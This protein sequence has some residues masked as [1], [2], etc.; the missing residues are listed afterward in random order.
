MKPRTVVLALFLTLSFAPS[1]LAQNAA[2]EAA[3]QQAKEENKGVALYFHSDEFDSPQSLEAILPDDWSVKTYLERKYVT[4]S[5]DADTEEGEI[6]ARRYAQLGV[7]PVLSLID[8]DG[9]QKALQVID[10]QTSDSKAWAH[11]FPQARVDGG[12]VKG[13]LI[14]S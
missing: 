12:R 5:L 14:I 3:L 13:R 1:L 6:L 4:L 8:S 2:F 9:E 11:F 7:F 10:P